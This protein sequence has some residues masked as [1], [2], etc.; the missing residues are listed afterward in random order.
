MADMT[1][2]TEPKK[3]RVRFAPSPTGYLHIGGLRTALYNELFARHH[4]GTFILR[5]E[6]TDRTRYVEG[7]VE[8]I[9]RTLDWAGLRPDEG[10][11]LAEDGSVK[12]RGDFGPYVQSARTDRYRRYAEELLAKIEEASGRTFAYRCFCTPEEI[13]RL[14]KEREEAGAAPL[15]GLVPHAQ[16]CRSLS[17]EESRVL[18]ETKPSVIRLRVPDRVGR[19]EFTDSIRGLVRFDYSSVDDQVLLKSDGFPTYHL[20][21]VIDDHEMAITQVIRG[22]EWLPSTPKHVLLYRAFGWEPPAFAHLPL[23]LNPDRTKLSK[24]QGDVAVEDYR[25]QGYLPEALVNFIALLGWNPSGSQEKYGKDELVK[26]FRL[27]KVNKAGAVFNR[28]KLDWL[29]GEYM[30]EM[31]DDRLTEAALPHLLAAEVLKADGTELQAIDGALT[32][33]ET[34]RRALS[35][36]KARAKTLADFPAATGYFFTGKAELKPDMIP[37]KKSTPEVAKERLYGLRDRLAGLTDDDFADAKRLEA[38][39]IPFVAERGWTNADSL[40]PLRVALSG[41]ERSPSPFEIAWAIGKERTIARIED[42]ISSL[43]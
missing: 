26:E 43:S 21:N 23:L 10:P 30:K 28:E 6:D 35:L 7:A 40:W 25:R 36:E 41:R 20:A 39:V 38:A 19:V 9:L 11:Y 13:E 4:G 2:S 5:I 33:L 17:E 37:W 34:V 27:E 14:K 29:N 15:S 18:A 8:N 31:S 42:A 24:R 3:Q 12:E 32:S 16:N 1:S 22:E